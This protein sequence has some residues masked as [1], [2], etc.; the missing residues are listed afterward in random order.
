MARFNGEDFKAVLIDDTLYVNGSVTVPNPSYVAGFRKAI[1]QGIT[2]TQLILDFGCYARPGMWT[3]QVVTIPVVY[4]LST[5][6][7]D[8]RTVLLR[9]PEGGDEFEL[10][11][12][13]KHGKLGLAAK[14]FKPKMA[15]AATH[16]V[17]VDPASGDCAVMPIG[18][19]PKGYSIYFVGTKKQCNEKCAN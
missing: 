10:Q 15:L 19:A 7:Q 6:V 1:P 9:D 3:Q 4:T 5:D 18:K 2:E 11:I 14:L 12:E 17:V 8:Y 16:M 13:K